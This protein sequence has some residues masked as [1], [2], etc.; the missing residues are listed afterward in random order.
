MPYVSG[1]SVIGAV[2]T[3]SGTGY[4]SVPQVRIV[5][6][7]GSGAAGWAQ[8]VSGMVFVT[9][10]SYGSGYATIPPTIQIDPP[11]TINAPLTNQI[12]ATLTLPSVTVADATNYF[13]VLTSNYG[14][15]TSAT[16]GLTVILPPQNFAIQNFPTGL[17]LQFT[18]T[19]NYPYILQTT[20]N[21][22]PPII[23]HS[24]LTNTTDTSGNCYFST[25]PNGGQNFYRGLGQ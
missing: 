1:G 14:S 17:G 25:L 13:V 6:G 11:S 8:V 7:S 18:G 5:G 24:I 19:P 10:T 3:D 15:V 16:V 21:L 9:I 20:T 22:T 4:S 12:N 2:M 23:W